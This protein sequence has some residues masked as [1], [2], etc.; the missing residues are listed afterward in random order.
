MQSKNCTQSEEGQR[1]LAQGGSDPTG[2]KLV[3]H[4][5]T[6]R[7][8]M[9]G[10][11]QNSMA[12]GNEYSPELR[13]AFSHRVRRAIFARKKEALLSRGRWCLAGS[14]SDQRFMLKRREHAVIYTPYGLSLQA[15]FPTKIGEAATRWEV[16]L[17]Q[18]LLQRN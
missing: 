10:V 14:R 16:F 11:F 7:P 8:S 13:Y 4:V 12:F 3:S 1:L 5:V 15:W 17:S 18:I 6:T 2:C 9:S